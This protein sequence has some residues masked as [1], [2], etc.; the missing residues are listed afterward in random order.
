MIIG[1]HII[2]QTS[3]IHDQLSQLWLGNS[4]MGEGVRCN[5]LKDPIV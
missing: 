1:V 4:R 2:D 5:M 3:S